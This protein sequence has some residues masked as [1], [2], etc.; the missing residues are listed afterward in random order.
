MLET[1]CCTFLLMNK[2]IFVLGKEFT[3]SRLDKPV[4]GIE[5]LLITMC[6][7][8]PIMTTDQQRNLNPLVIKVNAAT[9][10]PNKP[11]A[12]EELRLR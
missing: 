12:Y 3:T 6:T 7:N 8:G 9:N 10:M 11:M 5:D 2:L 4:S 1:F